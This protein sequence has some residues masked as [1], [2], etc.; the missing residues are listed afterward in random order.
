MNKK[1]EEIIRLK[2]ALARLESRVVKRDAEL[3]G[4][5][6]LSNYLL[7]TSKIFILC[8]LIRNPTILK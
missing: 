2:E 5:L 7:A 8:P 6:N 4:S 1:D 3:K